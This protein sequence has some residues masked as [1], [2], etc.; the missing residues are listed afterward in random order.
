MLKSFMPNARAFRI[1]RYSP[2]SQALHWITLAVIFTILPLA[3]VM[4]N[5]GEHNPA[6]Q[7]I[8]FFHKSFGVL[9]L[10]LIIARLAWRGA[11]KAPGLPDE[12]PKWEIGLAHTT[13]F[14]LYAIFIVMPVTGYI[15]SSAGGHPVSLFGLPLPQLPL[16]K[17]LAKTAGEIHIAGQYLVYFFLAAHILAIV[18]HVAVRKD[19]YLSRMLPEQINAE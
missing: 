6:R 5:M 15:S 14:F 9:A 12:T 3:W 11:H 19:G 10:L 18:W 16:D 17:S 2:L 4:V 1:G 8:F 13:H 7:T